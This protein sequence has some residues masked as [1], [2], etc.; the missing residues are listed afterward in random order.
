MNWFFREKKGTGILLQVAMYFRNLAEII[1]IFCIKKIRNL[2]NMILKVVKLFL[3]IQKKKKKIGKI[4]N[5]F[6]IKIL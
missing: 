4:V 6:W 3:V 5:I 2:R 1:N